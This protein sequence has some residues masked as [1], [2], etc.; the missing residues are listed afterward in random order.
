MALILDAP[1]MAAVSGVAR[2]RDEFNEF[3]ERFVR[4]HRNCLVAKAHVAGFERASVD[5]G[6]PHW[7]VL[8]AAIAE[9][10]P[11]SRRQAHVVREF[12]RGAK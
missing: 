11:V 6:E 7:E 1:A 2:Y 8:F 5:G 9:R 3:A 10:L 12:A 4:V